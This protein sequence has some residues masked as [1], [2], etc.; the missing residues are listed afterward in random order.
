MHDRSTVRPLAGGESGVPVVFR[1][2][3]F[4]V[5]VAMTSVALLLLAGA[6]LWHGGF[7][8]IDVLMLA[9]FAATLPWQATGLWNS[10]FGFFV[11]LFAGDP[12]AALFPGARVRE[13]EAV[14]TKTA[15]LICIRNEMPERIIR[16]LATLAAGLSTAGASEFFRV[17]VLSDTTDPAIA[18]LEDQRFG[19][20]ASKGADGVAVVY[21]RRTANAGF[22]AGNIRDFCER[23]GAESDFALILDADSFMSADAVLRLVRIM[24]HN[25]KLGIL[26]SLVVGL[27]ST[28][29]FARLFQFGMRLGMRSYTIGSAWWQAD[30]GPYWGHNAVIRLAPFIAHCQLA[31]LSPNGRPL[32]ILS[33]DQIEAVLMRRAG[34]EVRVLPLEQA[35]WEENPATLVEFI[36]RDLR[37]CH[38]NMQYWRLLGL[39]GIAFTSRYQLAF[40]IMMFLGSPGWIGL[41]IVGTALTVVSPTAANHFRAHAGA[42]LLG[43]TFAMCH[44]PKLVTFAH[45]VSHAKE[46]ARFG[47]AVLFIA[48]TMCET[49]FSTLL[50]PIMW[51]AHTMLLARL[52]FRRS[53]QWGTQLRDDHRVPVITALRLLW[54]QSVVGI[55]VVVVLACTHPAAIPY[56]L[57]LAAGLALSIPLAVISAMPKIGAALVRVGIG[58]LP[59]EIVTPSS[60]QALALPALTTARP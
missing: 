9:L 54:P 42:T 21:R 41:L 33:H 3:L 51:F 20:L 27:P 47:G 57:P 56:A 58:R 24:Q 26:Q 4:F 35:S 17:Y 23:W 5:L 7:D 8:A 31:D 45:I 30:C 12:V 53:A 1:R 29:A 10:T 6:V 32:Q 39:P 16:N 40:A 46:R 44:W 15:I 37:W 28:S 49:V 55:S 43:V 19:A 13:D 2:A 48:S 22:K 38:G 11:M 52:P 34:Y 18:A 59:E 60:L 25:P 50:A 36:R 14:T